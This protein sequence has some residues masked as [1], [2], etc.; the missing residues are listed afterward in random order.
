MANF[1]SLSDCGCVDLQLCRECHASKIA[2]LTASNTAILHKK[3]KEM[4][5]PQRYWGASPDVSMW[6][7]PNVSA[8]CS[9]K[10]GVYFFGDSGMGKTYQMIGW[11]K[12]AILHGIKVN[13]INWS[14]F[15]CTLKS[16]LKIYDK[17]KANTLTA[18]VVFIDD[19]QV[20][21]A[22]IEDY[23]FNFINT[24][25]NE[26]ITPFLTSINLPPHDRF[27]MRLGEMTVQYEVRN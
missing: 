3:L 4:S 7:K 16:D 26:G 9:F 13:Y 25:Y 10:T 20:G 27:A 22:Y 21:N 15:T 23:T 18:P 19:F 5:V 11:L 14:D 2:N 8:V 17:L 1:I 12:Y 6:A 24:I